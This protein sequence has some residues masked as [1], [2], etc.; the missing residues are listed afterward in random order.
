MAFV[1][2]NLATGANTSGATLS[3]TTL[4]DVPAGAAIVVG[5]SDRASSL[6][7]QAVSDSA[8][9]TY[10]RQ[11]SQIQGGNL[12]G[13]VYVAKNVSFLAAGSTITVTKGASDNV[14]A[15]AIL[16]TGVDTATCV[17]AAT[18]TS[19][20]VNGNASVQ[21]GTPTNANCLFIGF[22]FAPGNTGTFNQDS[23]HAAYSTPPNEATS[24]TAG[25]SRRVNGG[26]FTDSG[27]NRYTYGPTYSTTPVAAVAS[28][29]A[30]IPG[31][32]GTGGGTTYTLTA[33]YGS[34][35]LTG[36]S[37]NLNSARKL[38][39]SYGSFSLS[40][41]AATLK[42]ARKLTADYGSFSLA[43]QSATLKSAR[44]LVADYGSF[45]LSGQSA[46]LSS[47]RRLIAA[48]GT[49]ALS[50]QDALTKV[51]RL[52]Q[53]AFGQF[54]LSGQDASLTK[55]TAG[56]TDYTLLAGYGVF[57][58]TGEAANLNYVQHIDVGSAQNVGHQV[59][60]PRRQRITILSP[61]RPRTHTL[62]PRRPRNTTLTGRG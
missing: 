17:D 35:S 16:V 42:S 28:I 4:V 7:S 13:S 33:N 59:L 56:T 11:T 44:K 10:V 57:T 19:T 48:V 22:V 2:T 36:E 30:L 45:S 27:T 62:S 9:N 18:P 46:G 25:T 51:A 20:G 55:H 52:L 21:S 50:G 37:A 34:F 39:A 12:A 43:G 49:F 31:T 54:T 38:T 61:S 1:V 40:G 8:G 14:G 47:A 29:I 53:A 60:S 41:Q 3:L 24:G 58:L 5:I 15:S 23:T 32:G 26:S 6:T